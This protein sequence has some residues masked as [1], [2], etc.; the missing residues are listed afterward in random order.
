MSY[1]PSSAS[2]THLFK[3]KQVDVAVDSVR[4]V[5]RRQLS[6]ISNS[7]QIDI[8]L[9]PETNDELVLL[10]ESKLHVVFHVE[11]NKKEGVKPGVAGDD[12]GAGKIPPTNISVINL[13]LYT[14][15][16]IV[17]LAIY[18]TIVYT[19]RSHHF[20]HKNYMDMLKS[21]Q[22][23]SVNNEIKFCYLD[24][25]GRYIDNT[26]V[27]GG[28]QGLAS[29]HL[30]IQ[31]RKKVH[32]V[33]PLNMGFTES[34][35]LLPPGCETHLKLTR[36]SD[37]YVILS[38]AD[39]KDGFSLVLDDVYIELCHVTLRKAAL[40]GMKEV[41]LK[42]PAMYYYKETVM[43]EFTIPQNTLITTE[44]KV[45]DGKLPYQ[46]G[47]VLIT[48]LSHQGSKQHNPLHYLVSTHILPLYH[49]TEYQG[50][51]FV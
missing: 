18:Q 22:Y 42:Q 5:D 28:N 20:G 34:G 2:P 46:L 10:S 35:T 25:P 13:I 30:R 14:L 12:Q 41:L 40:L 44:R 8:D 4:Y 50:C 43:T 49:S 36:S 47:A 31:Q 11:N 9:S 51:G 33:G 39:D 6:N 26:D 24:S 19:A 15:F 48:T 21:F 45:V 37:D 23:R 17:E 29:R 1:V 38:G 7:N 3:S 16:E 32:C 27:E